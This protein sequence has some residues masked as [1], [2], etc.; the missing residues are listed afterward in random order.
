[1]G[2]GQI[3]EERGRENLRTGVVHLINDNVH[4]L[5][6]DYSVTRRGLTR[7]P[8]TGLLVVNIICKSLCC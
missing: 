5:D 3:G 1:M 7:L 8:T 6:N 4:L 2:A